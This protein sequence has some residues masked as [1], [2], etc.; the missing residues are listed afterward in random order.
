MES[1]H[2]DIQLVAKAIEKERA[3]TYVVGVFDGNAGK[4]ESRRPSALLTE[5]ENMYLEAAH[6]KI[7]RAW[8]FT[9]KKAKMLDDIVDAYNFLAMAYNEVKKN[10]VESGELPKT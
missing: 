9:G 2:D 8:H 7:T 6:Y 4:A 3:K 5:A 1:Y 10:A